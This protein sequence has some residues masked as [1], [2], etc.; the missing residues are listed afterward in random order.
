MLKTLFWRKF[1]VL[2]GLFGQKSHNN[3]AIDG[4]LAH[5]Y[6]EGGALFSM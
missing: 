5:P 3:G 4:K 6:F 1:Y 2:Q